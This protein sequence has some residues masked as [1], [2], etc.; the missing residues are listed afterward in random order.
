MSSNMMEQIKQY[1]LKHHPEMAHIYQSQAQILPD[2]QTNI[3]DR[4][5]RTTIHAGNLA[6][7]VSQMKKN[8]APQVKNGKNDLE[9]ILAKMKAEMRNF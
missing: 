7:T 9:S 5:Q 8:N 1:Y 3:S 6:E 2:Y 4:T